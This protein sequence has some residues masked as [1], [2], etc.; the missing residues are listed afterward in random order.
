VSRRGAGPAE[1]VT[2]GPP[3]SPTAVS[4][5]GGAAAAGRGKP[6]RSVLRRAVFSESQRC[7]LKNVFLKQKYI[8]KP[9]RRRLA[10]RLGLKD[11]QVKQ[12]TANLAPRPLQ[13]AATWR[14]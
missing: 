13:G 10:N 12:G 14:I 7:A 2:V 6:R 4:A 11:S 5:A 9:D 1:F 8:S 3:S